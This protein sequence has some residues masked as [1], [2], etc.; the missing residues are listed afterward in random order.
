M[1]N[2]R[3]IT[4]DSHNYLGQLDEM[5]N[6][7]FGSLSFPLVPRKNNYPPL[8]ITNYYEMGEEND[9]DEGPYLYYDIEVAL[10]GFKRDEIKVDVSNLNQHGASYK[11]IE[12]S[13]NK[14][15]KQTDKTYHQ[16]GIAERT[17]HQH[18]LVAHD[19]KIETAKYEDGI[20]TITI[21]K[22][23]PELKSTSI[24]IL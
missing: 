22:A 1:Q 14:E 17:I 24:E 23:K 19:D 21:H 13:A 3:R 15:T 8:N 7:A 11:K 16:Q 6:K 18:I 5:V 9:S 10:A 20:L 2:D 4:L 12:I